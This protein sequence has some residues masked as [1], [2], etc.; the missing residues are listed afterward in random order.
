MLV[1]TNDTAQ[2]GQFYVRQATGG[3][4]GLVLSCSSRGY[5]QHLNLTRMLD[6]LNELKTFERV[7]VCGSMYRC[8]SMIG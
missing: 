3:D 6:D 4:S 8:R 1:K 2:S 7:A 5:A